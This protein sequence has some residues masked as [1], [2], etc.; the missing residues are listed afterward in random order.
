MIEQRSSGGMRKSDD[1]SISALVVSRGLAIPDRFNTRLAGMCI[2]FFVASSLVKADPL[3]NWHP[4]NIPPNFTPSGVAFG[5]GIFVVVGTLLTNNQAVGQ[6]IT[7]A[8]GIAW[9]SQVPFP[10]SPIP[11]PYGIAYGADQFIAVGSFPY[12]LTSTDG[13]NWNTA[14]QSTYSRLNGIAYGGGRFVAVGDSGSAL[15]STNGSDWDLVA[16]IIVDDLTS[17]AYCAGSFVALNYYNLIDSKDGSNWTIRKPVVTDYN[18]P[19]G[20]MWAMAYGAGTYAMMLEPLAYAV[21]PQI[22]SSTDLD[23]WSVR[24]NGFSPT[25]AAITFANGTFV[26]AGG[27]EIAS[28]GD[29]ITWTGRKTLGVVD[30]SGISYGN[31]TFVAVGNGGLILQSDSFAPAQLRGRVLT[32]SA[33]FQLTITGEIGRTYRLQASAD[34]QVSNWVDLFTFTNTLGTTNFIDS[35]ATNLPKRFYRAISP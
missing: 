19:P 8:D 23:H 9:T 32:N 25:P 17:V 1:R 20:H 28:S 12:V 30:F 15:T 13:T 10:G 16:N 21:S 4:R 7:S 22:I 6:A 29:G 3:D 14:G 26:A 18:S 11:V 34:L 27:G 35:Y 31:S 24:H 33:G 2:L 5:N